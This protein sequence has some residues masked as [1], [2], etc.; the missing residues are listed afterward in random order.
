[1]SPT[2]FFIA[3]LFMVHYLQFHVNAYE[4][5]IFGGFQV[6]LYDELGLY[7]CTLNEPH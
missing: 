7:I 3:N 5:P 1:M 6:H 4:Y 2:R